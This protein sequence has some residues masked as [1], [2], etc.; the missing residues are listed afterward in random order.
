MINPTQNNSHPP[1]RAKVV[2]YV[3]DSPDDCLLLHRLVQKL[4]LRLD[5]R[6]VEDG[7]LAM[8]WLSGEGSKL[9]TPLIPDLLLTDLKMPR[10]DGFELLAWV[11]SQP[12]FNNMPVVVYSDS[13]HPQIAECC[14]NSGATHYVTKAFSCAEITEYLSAFCCAG[15]A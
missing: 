13:I 3:E 7:R 10:V 6:V 2:L 15:E 1:H 14:K 4:G 9:N 11:R 12:K 8:D 5:V